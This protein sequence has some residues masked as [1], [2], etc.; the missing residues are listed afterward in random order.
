MAATLCQPR[1]GTVRPPGYPTVS[2]T[3]FLVSRPT[4]IDD[5]PYPICHASL[6]VLGFRLRAG[7][8]HMPGRRRDT[9]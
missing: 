9:D 1:S 2:M 4:F 3:R 8:M 7:G 5:E 6:H